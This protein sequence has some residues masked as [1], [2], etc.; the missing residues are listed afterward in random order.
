M[1]FVGF[2]NITICVT[3]ESLQIVS[4]FENFYS[5]TFFTKVENV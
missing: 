1:T 2:E 5:K 3:K 4:R